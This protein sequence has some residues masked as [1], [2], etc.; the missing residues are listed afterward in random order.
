MN[1]HVKAGFQSHI[2]AIPSKELNVTQSRIRIHVSHGFQIGLAIA[3]K[4]RNNWIRDAA[5]QHTAG[6]FEQ[7]VNWDI[8]C[9]LVPDARNPVH[10][11]PPGRYLLKDVD[12]TLDRWYGLSPSLVGV[13][14][15]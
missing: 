14:N 7:S 13:R 4:L 10:P 5:L 3:K 2:G 9:E 8:R 1:G 12:P 6:G 15:A 11:A